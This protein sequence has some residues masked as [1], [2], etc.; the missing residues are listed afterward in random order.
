MWE[1]SIHIIHR[2]SRKIM[3][4]FQQDRALRHYPCDMPDKDWEKYMLTEYCWNYFIITVTYLVLI[5]FFHNSRWSVP[6]FLRVRRKAF[7]I[8]HL[9]K[10]LDSDRSDLLGEKLDENWQK[11][12]NNAKSK[13][14]T[15]NLLKVLL[16]TFGPHYF[17]WGMTL[18][19]QMTIR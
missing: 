10:V 4:F 9:H 11:E 7:E 6:L 17:M 5:F 14:R 12:Y 8:T 13:K 2:S 19:S 1:N 15:P 3:C 16:K 18:L